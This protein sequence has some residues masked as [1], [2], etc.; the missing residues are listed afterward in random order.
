MCSGQ[1]PEL[2]AETSFVGRWIDIL[3][4][5]FDRLP[6]G[7]DD[8]RVVALEKEGVLVSLENLMSFPFV[9]SRVQEGLLTLHGLWTDIG[10]GALHQYDADK[11]EFTPV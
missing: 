3:R 9:E 6:A 5:G 4:P 8:E 2:E 10:E 1:A 7:T 11:R